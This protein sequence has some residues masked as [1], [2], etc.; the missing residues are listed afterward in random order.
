MG[1]NAIRSE[2]S[3]R[4]FILIFCVLRNVRADTSSSIEKLTCA[5]F[6]IPAV[7]SIRCKTTS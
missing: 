1:Y 5:E 4:E 3:K 6:G 7:G 2:C